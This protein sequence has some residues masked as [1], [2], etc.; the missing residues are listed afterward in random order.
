MLKRSFLFYSLE[1]DVSM[2][3]TR[4]AKAELVCPFGNQTKTVPFYPFFRIKLGPAPSGL[5]PQTR[6]PNRD[7]PSFAKA[8]EDMN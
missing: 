5:G 6:D 2:R 3:S 4:N 7:G 1:Q 8:T